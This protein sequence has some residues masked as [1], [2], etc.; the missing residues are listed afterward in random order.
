MT[1]SVVG[2]SLIQSFLF[3]MLEPDKYGAET[4][5]YHLA[6]EKIQRAKEQFVER[7]TKRRDREIALE[8]AKKN[9]SLDFGQINQLFAQL[10]QEKKDDQ[11][12]VLSDYYHPSKSAQHY[13]NLAT[14]F[15]G[16]ATGGG[17]IAIATSFL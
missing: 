15:L 5:R 7:E 14:G 2:S 8:K 4:K 13:N 3:K 17:L 9:A 6:M 11:K 12:P 16:L 10:A 1:T